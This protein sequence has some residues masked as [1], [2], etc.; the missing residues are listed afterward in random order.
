MKHLLFTT[1]VYKISFLALLIFSANTTNAEILLAD[2]LLSDGPLSR[3]HQVFS[4][5]ELRYYELPTY[6]AKTYWIVNSANLEEEILED[7]GFWGLLYNDFYRYYHNAEI[8]VSTELKKKVF[9][10]S[11]LYSEMKDEMDFTRNILLSDTI[12]MPLRHFV[13]Y[14]REYDI[15]RGGFLVREELDEELPPFYQNP[16]PTT[17]SRYKTLSVEIISN[18]RSAGS[19]YPK[20]F[21]IPKSLKNKFESYNERRFSFFMPIAN[22]KIAVQI[23]DMNRPYDTSFELLLQFHYVQNPEPRI[24]LVDIILLS[25]KDNRI[26]WTLS[27]G[28]LSVI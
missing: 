27:K 2:S 18:P 21:V 7:Y 26:L 3:P 4:D 23:E 13:N 10:N 16:T 22:E 17:K 8:N 6:D 15:K 11:D 25:N 9:E 19:Y 24:E 28:D 14:A 20:Y 1:F 5:A 12:H